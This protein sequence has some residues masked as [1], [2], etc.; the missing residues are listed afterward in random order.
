MK[1]RVKEKY[2]LASR[3][4]VSV[5]VEPGEYDAERLLESMNNARFYGNFEPLSMNFFK[6]FKE[7]EII[8]DWK[9]NPLDGNPWLTYDGFRR[10]SG[11]AVDYS[12][13]LS[14]KERAFRKLKQIAKHLNGVRGV[15]WNNERQYKYYL[16]YIPIS[17]EWS[18]SRDETKNNLGVIFT[19]SATSLTQT[20]V[21]P[22]IT[23]W[24]NNGDGVCMDDLLED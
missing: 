7:F 21:V 15:D 11:G 5:N 14:K 4:G 10:T 1:I 17:K 20:E 6:N 3:Y 18:F 23:K 19:F 24:M 8:E 13:V 9:P 12:V 2:E 16:I 22:I